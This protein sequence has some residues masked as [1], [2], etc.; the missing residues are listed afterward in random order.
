MGDT[1]CVLVY[2]IFLGAF[3]N[4]NNVIIKKDFPN[5]FEYYDTPLYK[6]ITC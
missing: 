1:F 4:F 5:V 3:L 6:E 2:I